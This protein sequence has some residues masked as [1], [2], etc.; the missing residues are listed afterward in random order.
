MDE[1]GEPLYTNEPFRLRHEEPGNTSTFKPPAPLPV[2]G[3]YVNV[4]A[5]AETF[6]YKPPT[7]HAL[8]PPMVSPVVSSS[9]SSNSSS[10]GGTS[11][12]PAPRRATQISKQATIKP[13]TGID[14]RDFKFL[15]S[16]EQVVIT[17]D[18]PEVPIMLRN[19]QGKKSGTIA[20]GLNFDPWCLA[21]NKSTNEILVTA[22]QR[23]IVL[24]NS[25]G[26]RKQNYT[27]DAFS[28]IFPITCCHEHNLIA[29][30]DWDKT[31]VMLYD[32]RSN[33]V[34]TTFDDSHGRQEV[35]YGAM[36]WWPT[37]LA[38]GVT[39][40]PTIAVVDDANNFIKVFDLRGQFM[41]NLQTPDDKEWAPNNVAFDTSGGILVMDCLNSRVIR[42]AGGCQDDYKVAL[43]I[44][45][46]EPKWNWHPIDVTDDG[47]LG[48]DTTYRYN[49]QRIEVYKGYFC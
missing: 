8:V 1:N 45:A 21:V 36:A 4:A 5:I 26:Y 22:D 42:F 27:H 13:G 39:S 24:F 30:A 38:Y 28:R 31:C 46:M 41:T 7:T 29:V 9:V 35:V 18:N 19:F 44:G 34:T 32:P 16:K 23:Q 17:T 25:D 14:I 2:E 47:M 15:P 49:D 40:G 11:S 6:R 43:K 33:D 12:S 48:V 37:Y 3:E 20:Q 10:G